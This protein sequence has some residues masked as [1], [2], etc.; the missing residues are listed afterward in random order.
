MM[1]GG[2]KSI[3][4]RLVPIF[5]TLAPEGGYLHVGPSG[6]GHFVR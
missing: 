5:T 3:V 2:D 4:E 6:A 1:I